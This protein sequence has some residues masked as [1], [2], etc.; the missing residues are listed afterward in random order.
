MARRETKPGIGQV[1]YH[2][3]SDGLVKERFLVTGLFF[4]DV[5]F[6]STLNRLHLLYHDMMCVK[7]LADKLLGW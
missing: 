4:I 7:L 1:G 3:R 6:I 5:E 2:D